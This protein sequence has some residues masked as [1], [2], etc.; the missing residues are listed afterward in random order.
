[1]IFVTQSGDLCRNEVIHPAGIRVDVAHVE[2][3]KYGRRK[4]HL[5]LPPK[6]ELERFV[7][8]ELSNFLFRIL[9]NPEVNDSLRYQ[10]NEISFYDLV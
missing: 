9:Q 10:K 6:D 1:M 4:L 8:D 2:E 5:A 7:Q 3:G